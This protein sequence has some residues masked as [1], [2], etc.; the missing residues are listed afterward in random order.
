MDDGH[1]LLLS[2]DQLWT[3]VCVNEAFAV[4]F[5][6]AKLRPKIVFSSTVRFTLYCTDLGEQKPRNFFTSSSSSEPP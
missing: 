2:A 6:A 1:K 4:V 5:A 3:G